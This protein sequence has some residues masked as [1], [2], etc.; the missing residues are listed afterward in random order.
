MGEPDSMRIVAE[1]KSNPMVSVVIIGRNEGARLPRCI[2]SVRKIE[3]V[4]G[5]IEIIYVDSNSVDTSLTV[6]AESGARVFTVNSERSTA[7]LGRNIGWRAARG[8]YVLFLDG[9]TILH[10]GFLKLALEMITATPQIAAVWG[11]RREIDC[12]GSIYNRVLDLDWIYPPGLTEFCGGDVVM[13]RQ[14]LEQVNG[15]DSVLIAGEEPEL[16]RRLRSQGY[17][18]LHIDVPMTG[19][20][21][22]IHRFSQ[23]WTRALRAGHAYAEVAK[24]FKNTADPFWSDQR[25]QNFLRGG[26][27]LVSIVVV[28]VLCLWFRLFVPI[29]AWLLLL[30][31][32]AARTAWL[33]RWKSDSASTLFLYGIHSQLQQVP[34][35]L[36][37][38][39]FEYGARRGTASGLIE[40]KGEG[41]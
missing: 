33:A 11:H 20:D 26:F 25:R 41:K 22:A 35:L 23:Y 19:H 27:W 12:E 17:G 39:Q 31:G 10:P 40:Y 5:E 3:G 38:L 6:A 24:R 13:L 4:D 7:A 32:L 30:A 18:I 2:Q 1:A 8:E 29:F 34:I 21:L 14:A 9:D 28:L 36:G 15:F 37:Q 16:C